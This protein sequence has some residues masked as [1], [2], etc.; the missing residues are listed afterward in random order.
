MTVRL[1]MPSGT[2]CLCNFT[3][4]GKLYSWKVGYPIVIC[5][6]LSIL[7]YGFNEWKMKSRRN[8]KVIIG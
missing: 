1:P 7:E 4:Q 5:K 6:Q 2:Q 8:L 3:I